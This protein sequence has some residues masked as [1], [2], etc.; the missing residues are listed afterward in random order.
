MGTG[1]VL[2]DA[3]AAL[4]DELLEAAAQGA[5]QDLSFQVGPVELEFAVE[6]RLD[7]RAKGGFRAWVITGEAETGVSHVRTHRVKVALT[8]KKQ[9][10][11]DVLIH[12]DLRRPEGPGDVSGRIES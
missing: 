7:A 6:L 12:S 1:I 10:G 2:A 3:V 5:G 4:R 9:D 8:P 11:G